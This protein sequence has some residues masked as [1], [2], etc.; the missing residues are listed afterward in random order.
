MDKRFYDELSSVEK[1]I[2]KYALPRDTVTR[3]EIIDELHD[4]HTKTSVKDAFSEL[5]DENRLVRISNG[6]QY[7]MTTRYLF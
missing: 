3:D 5:C 2:I 7:T 1:E 4:D 6:S